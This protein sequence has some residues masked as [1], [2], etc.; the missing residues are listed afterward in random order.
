MFIYSYYNIFYDIDKR[1]YSRN[2]IKNVAE[3]V[4]VSDAFQL[5]IFY[6]LV[7]KADILRSYTGSF[8]NTVHSTTT[9]ILEYYLAEL[10]KL[11][12]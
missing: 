6:R 9:S 2:C 8:S 11:V 1:T 12:E 4:N 10:G 3:V 7:I 5:S